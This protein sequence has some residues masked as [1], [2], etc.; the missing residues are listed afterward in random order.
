MALATDENLTGEIEKLPRELRE[1]VMRRLQ[2]IDALD[3]PPIVPQH[4]LPTLLRM[5]A[6]SEYAG[7]V[8]LREADWLLQQGDK[9]LQPPSLEDLKV[10]AEQIGESSEPAELV[11][12]SIRRYRNRYFL[13]I[14]W[15]EYA[16]TASL[17]ETLHA[18]SDLADHLLRGAVTYAQREVKTRFGQVHDE[19]GGEVGLVVLGMGKLG[20]RE[21]NFSS[22]IDLIF[23]YPGGTDSD[24][25]RSLSPH[26]YFTRVSRTVISLIEAPTSD[27]FAFRVDTR[28]RP[29]GD[30]GP[31]VTSFAALESYLVQHGRGWE[32]YAYVKA[33]A[34][35]PRL[36]D[37]VAADLYDNMISPFVYRRYLDY[38][39]FESMR[40]MHA[41][42]ST[43]VKRRELADNVKLGPGGIREIEFIVQ[44]L[45]LVR[46]GEKV[47]LRSRE[48]QVVLPRL[49]GH[50]DIDLADV[51]ELLEAY[52]YLRR[53]E[54]FIQA[55]RDQ[56]THELPVDGAD[57]AR[58]ALA[59]GAADWAEF[60]DRLE[61]HRARVASHFDKIAFR[62]QDA[63][64]D[65]DL[66]DRLREIWKNSDSSADWTAVLQ[67][68]GFTDAEE[69]AGTLAAF[70]KLASHVDVAAG[71][72]LQQFVPNLLA[73]LMGTAHPNLALQRT[74]GV[75]E[76]VLRRSAYIALLNENAAA[77][78]KLVELC[79]RSAYIAKQLAQY[80]VLLDELLNP[81]IYVDRISKESM[82]A[83]LEARGA[84]LFDDDS[85]AQTEMLAKFQRATQFRIAV[86]D[87][88]ASLPIMRVSDCRDCA[89]LR[90]ADSLARPDRK[91]W[92]TG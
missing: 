44:S 92:H 65:D 5:L 48:L 82:V 8:F 37:E 21:L 25:D 31:P 40:E 64:R 17:N 10:F 2:Q 77:T 57:R 87:F 59:M 27:G 13:H 26:E 53:V 34:V 22:D 9:L 14:L 7:S 60:L 19:S 81:G 74:L 80:P 47:E 28:L 11:Q 85:E 24:G 67:K 42:I 46:G 72:R 3:A 36:S 38:G 78:A 45:Q 73:L 58:I 32:R 76:K 79:T 75:V 63:G 49:A 16:A 88:N 61:T 56:Q 52:G 71:Q 90:V 50:R 35:G 51:D 29:F 54:N 20:G 69:L 30:S 39:V 41:L 55:I 84:D 23:L 6:C 15:R 91:T 12:S 83:E 33:R 18:I 89:G 1:P 86:A 62:E 4:M 43:E 70:S 66:V 68:E